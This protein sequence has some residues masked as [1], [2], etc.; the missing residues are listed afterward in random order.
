M[1][2]IC[3]CLE[4]VRFLLGHG[5]LVDVYLAEGT[6]ETKNCCLMSVMGRQNALH[7]AT[8][9]GRR[10]LVKLL[11]ERGADRSFPARSAWRTKGRTV[12]PVELARICGHEDLVD[13]LQV[14]SQNTSIDIP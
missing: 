9:D 11:I 1:R 3:A 10:D 5:A 7:F 12:F 14:E 4:V 6:I 8:G 2:L 13:L